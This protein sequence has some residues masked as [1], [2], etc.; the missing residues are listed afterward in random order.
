MSTILRSTTSAM[1]AVAIT[2]F[3][4]VG[5]HWLVNSSSHDKPGD[6][7]QISI[8]FSPVKIDEDINQKQRRIPKKPPPPKNP[9][10]PPKMNV[11]SNQQVVNNMPTPTI[12][13][14]DLGIG[15]DGPF[16]GAMGAGI[17]MGKDGGIIPM[18]T[19][20]P[21]YPRKAAIAKIEGWV[22]MSFTITE[23]GTV[24]NPKV[25]ASKPIRIFDREALRA[26]LKY[27]FKPKIENGVAMTQVATQKLNSN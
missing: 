9:P 7:D 27:K 20:A 3:L 25:I 19:I 6:D 12:P 16:L 26:I 14:L 24:I 15:G 1:P 13:S 18:V 4:F 17:D 5:M 10:P 8:D 21:N 2:F 23:T 22:E 11:Q